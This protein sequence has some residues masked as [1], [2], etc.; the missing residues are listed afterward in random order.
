[1]T[2]LCRLTVFLSLVL[3]FNPTGAFVQPG[4]NRKRRDVRC[5]ESL[6]YR[7]G[8]ICCLNCPAGQYL[9]SSCTTAGQ[10]GEC[11]QCEDGTYTEHTNHLDKCFKCTQ[12][13]SDQEVVSACTLTH[14]TECRCRAGSFCAPDQA[15]EVCK[16]CSRCAKDEEIVRNCTSTINTECKK[17]QPKPGSLSVNTS[18]VLPISL[19]AAF[20]VVA[21]LIVVCVRM[22]HRSKDPGADVLDCLK[23]EQN[24]CS[25]CSPDDGRNGDAQTVSCS[26]LI[27]TRKPVRPRPSVHEEDERKGLCESLSSSASNSQH[28]LTGLP[29]HPDPV[30]PKQPESR[31]DE[32]FP[33]L[34]PVNGEE[35]LRKC[36][37]YFEDIDV[38][39]HKRFFRHLNFHDN[40]IK[41][42]EHLTYEDRIHE[43]LN[44]WIEREGREASLNVLLRA[45]LDLN[46]RRTAE[47]IKEK[48]IHDGHYFSQE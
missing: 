46:Q 33:Q 32:K 24:D 37:G 3:S 11:K 19:V 20:A 18:V 40:A 42:K 12:C 13:R 14:N 26:G 6:E 44:V 7:S 10:R 30:T 27:L 35:S 25:S 16:K 48:A 22:R 47:I 36:F 15:C 38:D 8:S 45:L 28:S 43:L 29:P 2:S 41:S 31:A 21:L 1:M 39:Y 17:I 4:G 5:R 23:A 9:Q 34:V